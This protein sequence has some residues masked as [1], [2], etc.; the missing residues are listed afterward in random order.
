MK[1]KTIVGIFLVL[2]IFVVGSIFLLAVVN[3]GTSEPV[4]IQ[5]KN[6]SEIVY[7]DTSAA[8]AASSSQLNTSTVSD[9]ATSAAQNNPAP[10]IDTTPAQQ[11]S[12]PISRPAPMRRTRAS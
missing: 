12:A 2:F 3:P 7:V 1:L 5:S 6:A 10:A 9:V 11:P 4:F 8:N